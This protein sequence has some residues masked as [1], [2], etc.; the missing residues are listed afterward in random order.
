MLSK[1][2]IRLQKS[3]TA[4]TIFYYIVSEGISLFR[5]SPQSAPDLVRFNKLPY[6]LSHFS[7]FDNPMIFSN[8]VNFRYFSL[9][10]LLFS[11]QSHTW[12]PPRSFVLCCWGIFS[13]PLIF[14]Q[15]VLLFQVAVG[16]KSL[17]WKF[18]PIIFLQKL[19]PSRHS[20]HMQTGFSNTFMSVKP[21]LFC[22]YNNL[23]I[24]L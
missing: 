8:S 9:I 3:A 14:P 21:V 16:E 4:T 13:T 10:L 22:P 18:Y 23:P 1:S 17:I 19:Y 12:L 20:F 15:T 2:N 24:Y 5:L 11:L 7:P 6:I